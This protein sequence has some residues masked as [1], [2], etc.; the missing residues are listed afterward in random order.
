MLMLKDGTHRLSID[1]D[2]ICP[3][4]TDVGKHLGDF[5]DFGF[6][7]IEQVE[8]VGRG[9]DV[10]KGHAKFFYQIAYKNNSSEKSY[11]LLDVLYEALHY[12]Q[13][14]TVDIDSPFVCQTGKPTQVRVPSFEDILGDKLTAFAPN[15][16]GIPY[17]KG[18]KCCSMEIIKQLYDIGRL[19]D[20]VADVTNT[21]RSFGKISEIELGYRKMN[22]N[23]DDVIKDIIDTSLCLSTRGKDGVGDMALLQDGILRMK[24]FVFNSRYNIENAIV[25]A[26]KAAYLALGIGTGHFNIENFHVKQ[27][28]LSELSL[29]RCLTTRLNKLKVGNPEAFYYWC[30]AGELM[31]EWLNR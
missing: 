25:D 21:A 26:S 9:S 31:D 10:P 16:T 19:F 3:P 5:A 27:P 23:A 30:K 15:T 7:D 20:N 2:I 12:E 13:L 11:I 1:I 17:Y 28:D 24:P 14:N 6:T 8:R 18:D 22:G 29:P 4:G